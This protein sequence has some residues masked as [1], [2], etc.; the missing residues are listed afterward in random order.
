MAV[1]EKKLCYADFVRVTLLRET[2]VE[3]VRMSVAVGWIHSMTMV[4]IDKNPL[5][6]G[7]PL[8]PPAQDGV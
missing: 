3:N 2:N 6:R 4:V 8:C 1:I 7:G 5:R